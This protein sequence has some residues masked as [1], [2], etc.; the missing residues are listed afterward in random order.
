MNRSFRQGLLTRSCTRSLVVAAVVTMLSGCLMT[1]LDDS[2]NAMAAQPSTSSASAEV[3]YD[4]SLPSAME[5]L[6]SHDGDHSEP[7]PTF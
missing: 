4:P 1:P 6:A 7:A 5:A 2:L 3:H